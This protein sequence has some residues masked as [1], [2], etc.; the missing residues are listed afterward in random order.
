MQ[1]RS[2]TYWS[3][4]SLAYWIFWVREKL[5][6]PALEQMAFMPASLEKLKPEVVTK[7]TG[8]PTSRYRFRKR[9]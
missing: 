5:L 3:G 6:Q 7:Y 1:G 9:K 8:G 4:N 2:N